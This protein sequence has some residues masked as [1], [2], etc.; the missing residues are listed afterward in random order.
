[1]CVCVQAFIR[2]FEFCE[3]G[4]RTPKFGVDVKGVYST[5]N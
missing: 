2:D 4:W 3:R 5:Y 1:M